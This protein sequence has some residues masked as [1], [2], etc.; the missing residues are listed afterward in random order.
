MVEILLG[1]LRWSLRPIPIL[2]NLLFLAG[3]MR[4]Y[5]CQKILKMVLG[6]LPVDKFGLD[7]VPPSTFVGSWKNLV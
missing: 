7:L 3:V 1:R 4:P 5:L 6:N 2:L